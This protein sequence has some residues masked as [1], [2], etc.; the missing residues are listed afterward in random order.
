[1]PPNL[2]SELDVIRDV[3]SRLNAANIPFMVT[4]SLAMNYYADASAIAE[5]VEHQSSFNVIHRDSVIKVDCFP[6]KA[7]AFHTTEFDRRRSVTIDGFSTYV[8][9]RED[10]IVSKLLWAKQSGSDVQL[11]DVRNLAGGSFDEAYVSDWVDRLGLRDVW[12]RIER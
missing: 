12:N 5:A 2:P 10:L 8:V 11:R 9:T 6:R 3:S 7:D 4:G 1:M